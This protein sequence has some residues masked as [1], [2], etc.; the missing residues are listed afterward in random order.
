MKPILY[1]NPLSPFTHKCRIAL[2]ERD[3]AF[4]LKIPQSFGTGTP[5][6]EFLALNPRGEVPVLIDGDTVVSNSPFIL[7]YIQDRWPNAGRIEQTPAQRARN[8][9][10]E[11]VC[12]TRLD[13]VHWGLG[14]AKW[15]GRVPSD[16]LAAFMARS[17]AQSLATR[18]WLGGQLGDA[19]WFDG[20]AFGDT[21]TCVVVHVAGG[22]NHG[23]L[24]TPDTNLGAWFARASQRPTVAA[25][26]Q[27]AQ[28]WFASLKP[29]DISK[30]MSVPRQYR[31]HRLEWMVKG[32]GFETIAQAHAVGKIFFGV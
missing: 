26:L 2:M 12:D 1:Y 15:F 31:D 18:L 4:D 24:P 21:D 22:M 3:I 29:E 10:I 8:A 23:F 25:V 6:T 16:T 14:E 28:N 17:E 5:D 9:M 7:R 27:S 20:D 11:H 19:L 13:P 30:W 32:V